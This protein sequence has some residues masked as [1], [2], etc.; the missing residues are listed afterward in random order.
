MSPWLNTLMEATFGGSLNIE[1]FDDGSDDQSPMCYE[2]AVV[3]RHNEGGM[4]REK[5][6]EVYDLIRC[7][8]RMMCGVE[9]DRT[10]GEIGLTMLL[11]TGPRSFRNETAVV[12]IFERECKKVE[13]CRLTVAYSSNLTICEQVIQKI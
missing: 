12:Q 5:R 13:S 3:M 9:V 6:M 10:D 1:K 8:A 4:S 7:K 2:K 11:R